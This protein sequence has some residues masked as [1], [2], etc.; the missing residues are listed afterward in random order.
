MIK[1][2]FEAAAVVHPEMHSPKSRAIYGI[3]VMLDSSFQPK[4]LEVCTGRHSFFGINYKAQFATHM[5]FM[6]FY[7]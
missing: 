2:V 5:Y 3:D 7:S 1:S 4:L 6:N